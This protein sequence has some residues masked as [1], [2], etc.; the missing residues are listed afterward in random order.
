MERPRLPLCAGIV[1]LV[2]L[3]LCAVYAARN[4][5]STDEPR[6]LPNIGKR[7]PLR[8]SADPVVRP[9]G[10]IEPAIPPTPGKKKVLVEKQ[11][12]PRKPAPVL[13]LSPGAQATKPLAGAARSTT[14]L[15]RPT[16]IEAAPSG[17]ATT[18]PTQNVLRAETG[19]K[20]D[21]PRDEQPAG[22]TFVIRGITSSLPRSLATGA[23][24]GNLVTRQKTDFVTPPIKAATEPH[25]PPT[26]PLVV[27]P[28]V[29]EAADS[30]AKSVAKSV[31]NEPAEK[32][33]AKPAHGLAE[34]RAATKLRQTPGAKRKID[35]S[36]LTPKTISPKPATQTAPKAPTENIAEDH[37]KPTDIVAAK[38]S[39]K[40]AATSKAP[41]DKKSVASVQPQADGQRDV[42]RSTT[43]TL[44]PAPVKLAPA[45][46]VAKTNETNSK[47]AK[48]PVAR[49]EDSADR[50]PQI[51]GTN[52]DSES[53][54]PRE[55]GLQPVPVDKAIVAP[56]AKIPVAAKPHGQSG[57]D[58]PYTTLP[59]HQPTRRSPEL[60]AAM[61]RANARVLRGYELASRGALFA[62]RSEFI[63]AVKIIALAHDTQDGTRRHSKAAAAGLTALE[64]AEDFAR[65]AQSLRTVDISNIIIPH[66]TPVLKEI[67]TSDLTPDA[68]ARCYYNY[69]QEQLSAS[70]AQELCGSMALYAMGKVAMVD[71]K[72]KRKVGSNLGQAMTLYRAALIANPKNFRAA[73]E[74][75]VLLAENGQFELARDLLIRSV[76][77]SPQVTT[78]N[79][80]AAIHARIGEGQLADRAKR[81]ALALQSGNARPTQAPAVE[82]VDPTTFA[83]TTSASDALPVAGTFPK[84]APTVNKPQPD[85]KNTPVD[86]AKKSIKDWLKPLRR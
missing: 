10:L 7:L 36:K 16:T 80:L 84:Q 24:S 70:V 48:Q 32:A 45:P 81:R 18:R 27:T 3:A 40:I 41:A 38:P 34:R 25:V 8:P 28:S 58:Q 1:V 11:E 78:W 31:V 63:G 26:I 52:T 43:D 29:P 6:P 2:S 75:G 21:S 66:T 46:K 49:S 47:I 39:P 12:A 76:S 5:A 23:T 51:A 42:A 9:A 56:P 65:H 74:L 82:W 55:G 54:A 73:N 86:V 72:Q 85:E 53:A 67:D 68:A 37:R 4:R 83:S 71:A 57:D 20:P 30:S 79:N 59:W 64:E 44:A 17:P 69:A 60:V 77:E 19:A 15:P 50:A 22:T 61:K 33:A 62:G 13:K 14:A 35:S